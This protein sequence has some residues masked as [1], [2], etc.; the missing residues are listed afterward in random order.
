MF[1]TT[2]GVAILL[3]GLAGVVFSERV[4]R[5]QIRFN[6]WAL[7]LEPFISEEWTRGSVIIVGIFF[8][9]TGLGIALHLIPAN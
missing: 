5:S 8:A 3:L 7:G 1:Q 9:I 2:I 4:A 6:R